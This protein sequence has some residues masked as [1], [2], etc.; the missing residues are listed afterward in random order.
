MHTLKLLLKTTKEDEIFIAS[1][2]SAIVKVHNAFVAEG[3]KQLRMLQRDKRYRY[4]KKH[5]GEAASEATKLDKSILKVTKQIDEC[6]DR[7]QKKVLREQLKTLKTDWK[8]AEEFRKRMSSELDECLQNY[9]LS[10]TAMDAYATTFNKRYKGL[11]NS[12]QIQV[13]AERV[14]AGMEKVLFGDGKDIH[15][16]KYHDFRTVRGKQNSTGIRFFKEILSVSWLGRTIPVAYKE[17]L[18]DAAVHG[19][20]DKNLAY[21]LESLTGDIKYCEI[22]REEF[23]DG[24]HYYVNLYIDGDAPKKI[25]PGKGRCGIDPG[26]S[27]LA[28]AA[29]HKLILEELAPDYKKYDKEIFHLQQKADALRRKLNPQ[30]FAED[31]TIIR[32]KPGQKRVWNTSATYEKLM[33]KIRVL[34]RKKS[35][36]IRQ[37]HSEL[38]NKLLACAD[39]FLI[40]DMNFSALAKRAKET[41]RSQKRSVVTMADGTRKRD[42]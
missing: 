11:L 26:V 13:E 24:Y 41:K 31:G 7:A 22:L 20:T 32:M 5:Y 42:L 3:K 8:Q 9:G 15:Y 34:Y 2:F 29:E 40:E 23:L 19:T 1:V 25:I 6:T 36:Y 28:A 21:K 30:N 27:T 17:R 35:A 14:W 18:D 39:T 33:Q 38:C 10:K 12:Q 4:A 16:K 37:S